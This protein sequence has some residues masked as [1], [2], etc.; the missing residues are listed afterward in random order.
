M[1]R[2]LIS[3]FD[4][5]ILHA[6]G[7]RILFADADGASHFPDVA[8]LQQEMDDI[9]MQQYSTASEEEKKNWQGGHGVVVGSRAHLVRTEA[10][11]KVRFLSRS[12]TKQNHVLIFFSF[13]L[14]FVAIL[15][16]KLVDETVS[17]L[18]VYF[19][20]SCYQRHTVRVRFFT[21]L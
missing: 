20:N 11:V 3:L 6:S 17:H 12:C 5:G 4:K 7:H 10:V 16:E 15:F 19:G 13:T 21:F 8:L 18:S 9:E 2:P 1:I 14:D